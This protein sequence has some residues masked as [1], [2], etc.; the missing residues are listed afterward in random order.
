L[1]TRTP[2]SSDHAVLRDQPVEPLQRRRTAACH[3]D[4][5]TD[6][7]RRFVPVRR[8]TR[9]G[10][11]HVA[12]NVRRASEQ[13]GDWIGSGYEVF[14]TGLTT[15]R[16][17]LPA[18]RD[19]ARSFWHA[20]QPHAHGIGGYI[21][22]MVELDEDRIRASYGPAKYARLAEIKRR[23]DPDNLFHLNANIKPT[24]S[25]WPAGGNI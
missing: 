20:L 21:N 3:L 25:R 7:H 11:D 23:Y 18:E 9:H 8:R 24:G 4:E 13:G 10:P 15:T 2:C 16:E 6:E 5:L 19:W 12:D 22:A 14:V 17:Q 1:T